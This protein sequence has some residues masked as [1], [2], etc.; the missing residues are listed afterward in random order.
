[1]LTA[2]SAIFSYVEALI[3]FSF[4]VPG[5]KLGLANVVIVFALYRL[6]FRFAIVI[7]VL[8]VAIVSMLFGNVTMAVYSL[9][10]TVASIIV[11]QLLKSSGLFSI[12]GIS[13]AGGVFHNAAQVCVAA[14]VVETKGIFSYL[15]VLIPVG[16]VTGLLMGYISW[17]S[18]RHIR[19]MKR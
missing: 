6:G 15:S 11:M 5:I 17:L 9:A 10:G 12:L 14:A 4:G 19:T 7:S 1:M 3:P 2:L 8:R 18:L 16:M 13:M